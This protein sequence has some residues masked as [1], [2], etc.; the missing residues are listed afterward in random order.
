MLKK[1]V[2]YV[3]VLATLLPVT[4]AVGCRESPPISGNGP[5]AVSVDQPQPEAGIDY[6]TT[7]LTVTGRVSNPEATVTVNDTTAEVSENG[8]FSARIQLSEKNG[9]ITV[10]AIL[11][12]EVS[13]VK[14]VFISDPENA[15]AE[16]PK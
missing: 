11:G 12:D 7:P 1:V 5:L 14:T 10:K 13:R 4:P 2:L 16:V 3:A 9:V 15:K 8:Y 6:T